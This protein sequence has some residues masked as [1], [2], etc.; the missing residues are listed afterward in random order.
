MFFNSVTSD[1]PA[2]VQSY[3]ADILVSLLEEMDV[4]DA[5]ILDV[6]MENLLPEVKVRTQTLV[7]AM[8]E[9]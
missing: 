5:S 9:L 1:T 7:T 6:I 2:K 3:M 8:K 4:I